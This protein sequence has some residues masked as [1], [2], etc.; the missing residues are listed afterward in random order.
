MKLLC[1]CPFLLVTVRAFVLYVPPRP[2]MKHFPSTT[3]RRSSSTSST[4]GS[5]SHD[6]YHN[7]L[8]YLRQQYH[9]LLRQHERIRLRRGDGNNEDDKQHGN[10]S[11][12][13]TTLAADLLDIQSQLTTAA[14]LE[15]KEKVAVAYE[16]MQQA[17]H[18]LQWA[19]MLREQA[20]REANWAVDESVWLASTMTTESK[21]MDH[22]NVLKHR[23]EVL[24]Q[25]LLAHAIHD[26]KETEIRWQNARS[27]RLA[28]LQKEVQAKDLLW[29]LVQKEETLQ[30]LQQCTDSKALHAW[31]EHEIALHKKNNKNDNDNSKLTYQ[32]HD[33]RNEKDNL[34]P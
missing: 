2:G 22:H 32:D 7:N 31:L 23:N 8:V 1:S 9:N 25:T 29:S 10:S 14:R 19:T 4:S 18:E 12:P 28:A 15:Q 20:Q 34:M 27:K 16:E 6:Q 21:T 24:E 26:L 17:I 5:A 13:I 3:S 30:A 11:M 33:N